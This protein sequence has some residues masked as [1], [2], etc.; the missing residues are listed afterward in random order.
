MVNRHTMKKTFIL[1]TLCLLSFFTYAQSYL[2]WT[3]AQVNFRESP[4]IDASIIKSLKLGSEVFIVSLETENDFYDII[5]IE[6]NKEGFIHK[7]FVKIGQ[8]VE[9][10]EKGMFTP[11]GETT[12]Y[13]PDVEIYNKTDLILT[14]KLNSSFY[15]ISPNEKRTITI[16]PGSFTY[17]AS[18]PGVIPAIGTE[19]FKSNMIYTW[20]FWIVTTRR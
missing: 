5:N 9:E 3:T 11:S 10:S 6:T 15:S 2:G 19:Y 1:L 4:N 12:S 8:L 17:R 16:S 18:A 20:E 14:L 7:S 13:N